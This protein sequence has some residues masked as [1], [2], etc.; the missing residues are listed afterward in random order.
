MKSFMHSNINWAPTMY[1][2]GRANS[3][4]NRY[5]PYFQGIFFLEDEKKQ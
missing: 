1:H 3:K 5:G 2:L 4:Q